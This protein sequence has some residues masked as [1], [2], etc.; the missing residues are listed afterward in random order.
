MSKH[1]FILQRTHGS[2]F[3]MGF[4]SEGGNPP[5]ENISRYLARNHIITQLYNY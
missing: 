2:S 4:F 3:S 5:R 1:N